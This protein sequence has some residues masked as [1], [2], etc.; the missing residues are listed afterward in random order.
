MSATPKPVEDQFSDVLGTMQSGSRNSHQSRKVRVGDVLDEKEEEDEDE[1]NRE[2]EIVKEVFQRP[3]G[4]RD[5]LPVKRCP[6]PHEG[7]ASKDARSER[8]IETI[9]GNGDKALQRHKSVAESEGKPGL[10][11]DRRAPEDTKLAPDKVGAAPDN[12]K[13]HSGSPKVTRPDTIQARNFPKQYM[14]E[15]RLTSENAKPTSGNTGSTSGNSRP[16]PDSNASSFLE[17]RDTLS[18]KNASPRDDLLVCGTIRMNDNEPRV[19][20]DTRSVPQAERDLGRHAQRSERSIL[21]DA[22]PHEDHE[23]H[24][25]A[26]LEVHTSQTASLSRGKK[27]SE[28]RV[29]HNVMFMKKGR[30]DGEFSSGD[31]ISSKARQKTLATPDSCGLFCSEEDEL[32]KV[33]ARKSE[34]REVDDV[35]PKR[36]AL[37]DS[38]LAR[39]ARELSPQHVAE[40]RT[41]RRLSKHHRQEEVRGSVISSRKDTKR[42]GKWGD[43]GLDPQRRYPNHT[44]QTLSDSEEIEISRKDEEQY[45]NKGPRRRSEN[46]RLEEGAVRAGPGRRSP[47]QSDEKESNA[48]KRIV[49]GNFYKLQGVFGVVRV[50]YAREGDSFEG[51]RFLEHCELRE[52]SNVDEGEIFLFDKVHLSS[53]DI[54][55]ACSVAYSRQERERSKMDYFCHRA[56]SSFKND[57]FEIG[58]TQ[59]LGETY[60]LSPTKGSGP[61][62]RQ[63]GATSLRKR[64]HSSGTN[65]KSLPL[66][67]KKFR[68]SFQ[69]DTKKKKTAAQFFEGFSFV[70]TNTADKRTEENLLKRAGGHVIQ[71]IEEYEKV[72]KSAE[73]PRLAVIV[74]SADLNFAGRTPK[75]LMARAAGT[76]ILSDSWIRDCDRA[77]CIVPVGRAHLYRHPDA[78]VSFEHDEVFPDLRNW[79]S[80]APVE[81]RTFHHDLVYLLD[82]CFPDKSE[83]SRASWALIL[84]VAGATLA[85]PPLPC[86][87]PNRRILLVGDTKALQPLPTL[88]KVILVSIDWLAQ[89]L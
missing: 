36:S 83:K 33:V 27:T 62:G 71:T 49:E 76:P 38:P 39:R 7:S 35:D 86:T 87:F 5:E 12:A 24:A 74:G 65:L 19:R 77:Q 14:E 60:L 11:D 84:T 28:R 82:G 8:F 63:R 50:D 23:L 53:T 9:S 30:Q 72:L 59:V 66:S 52:Y 69:E 22:R 61:P 56:F 18:D 70:L 54:A 20:D 15:V 21:K 68:A 89:Q 46:R 80:F 67:K 40:G 44:E 57:F 41:M 13:F 42:E 73:C 4:V 29:P 32:Q 16:V 34:F 37:A 85:T 31:H 78:R 79:R 6:S 26:P 1:D 45:A 75:F 88:D 3:V 51:T 64:R 2:V 43:Q 58:R 10:D 48:N 47:H 81:S 55:C 17:V 25:S